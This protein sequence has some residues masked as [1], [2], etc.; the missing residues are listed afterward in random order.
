[1]TTK[2]K[3]EFDNNT[4]ETPDDFFQRCHNEFQF[5]LDAAA[6]QG[7]AKLG[8]YIPPENDAL[9]TTQKDERIWI[10]PPYSDGQ[11]VAWC[12]WMVEMW[13]DGNLVVALLPSSTQTKWWHD[14][15]MTAS[16]IRF[17]RGRLHFMQNK[18]PMKQPR[19]N[20]VLVVWEPGVNRTPVISSMEARI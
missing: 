9:I 15:I 6:H 13:Q 18:T 20:N 11:M 10:N 7:N 1:M 17:I 2:E 19:H 4:W 8:R 5:T 12:E 14:S 3:I 16:E